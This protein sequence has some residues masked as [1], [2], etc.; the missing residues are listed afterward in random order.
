MRALMKIW[1]FS[2]IGIS[3]SF[4]RESNIISDPISWVHLVPCLIKYEKDSK[5]RWSLSQYLGHDESIKD[6][7][8]RP[9]SKIM[10]K[11]CDFNAGDIA[12]CD[13]QIRLARF[14]VCRHEA[15]KKCDTWKINRGEGFSNTR[16]GMSDLSNVRSENARPQAIRRTWSQAV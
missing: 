5:V 11:S 8:P 3:F 7:A 16:E 12:F 1:S 2:E 6:M 9:V 10:A 15:G 13:L 14:E 4:T